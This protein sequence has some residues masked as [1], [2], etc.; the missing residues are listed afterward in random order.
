VAL[1][2]AVWLLPVTVPVRVAVWLPALARS[3]DVLVQG[4]AMRIIAGWLWLCGCVD[5]TTGC[6]MLAAGCWLWVW[7]RE[8]DCECERTW[9]WL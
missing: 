9:Q 5:V 2:M 8:S 1:G 6:W 7:L 4:A 3:A